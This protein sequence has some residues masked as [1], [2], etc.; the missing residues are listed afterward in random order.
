MVDF[1]VGRAVVFLLGEGR[2]EKCQGSEG[3]SAR[4]CRERY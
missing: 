3:G 2:D 4:K 1:D